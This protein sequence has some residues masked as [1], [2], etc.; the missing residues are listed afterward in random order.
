MSGKLVPVEVVASVVSPH[1]GCPS[2]LAPVSMVIFEGSEEGR[3]GGSSFEIAAQVNTLT[4]MRATRLGEYC[5]SSRDWG[6]SLKERP[7]ER[8]R[9]EGM[10]DYF[11]LLLL[12]ADF[13]D[14][15]FQSNTSFQDFMCLGS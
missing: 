7:L 12:L 3:G 9:K 13:F 11:F 15:L 5:E 14:L 8:R 4:A 10:V 1:T 6:R 2:S